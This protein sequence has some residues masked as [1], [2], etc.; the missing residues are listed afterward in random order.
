[1]VCQRVKCI[2]LFVCCQFQQSGD[3]QSY[4]VM[5]HRG[6]YPPFIGQG[7]RQLIKGANDE[8]IIIS[9]LTLVSLY[10]NAKIKLASILQSG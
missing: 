4:W 1:M 7:T 5:N 6:A 9:Y 8:S 10:I 2:F 3:F